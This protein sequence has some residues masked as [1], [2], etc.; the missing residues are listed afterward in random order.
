M[1]DIKEIMIEMEEIAA[2]QVAVDLSEEE[3]EEL[4]N[5]I[6]SEF[7]APLQSTS[8]NCCPTP[9][10][11]CPTCDPQGF[12]CIV[13]VPD[14]FTVDTSEVHAAVSPKDFSVVSGSE[15]A[16]TVTLG[17]GCTLL[18]KKAKV[19]G[20]AQVFASLCVKDAQGNCTFVC[21][22]DCVC[23]CDQNVICCGPIT[24]NGIK[25]T[26]SNLQATPI[27]TND[28]TCN[29]SLYTLTGTITLTC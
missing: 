28:P 22:S 3:K 13:T 15:G 6:N 11:A 23:F 16:C 8:S 25:F 19:N 4:K 29:K 10:P 1:K 14:G 7:T 12:C 26:V 9:P 5:L 18:L 21:C 27:T 17:N 2:N 24:A 20:C